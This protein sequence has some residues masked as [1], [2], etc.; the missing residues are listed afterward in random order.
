[1]SFDFFL[2]ALI[3]GMAFA[4]LGLGVYLTLRIFNIPDITT[5]GS[6]TLGGVVTALALVAGWH[7]LLAIVASGLAGSL[8][9]A[10]CGLIHT[11]LNTAPLLAGI[12]MMTALYSV[13]LIALGRPNLPLANMEPFVVLTGLSNPNQASLVAIVLLALL[14]GAKLLYLL[15]TDFGLAMRA[16]GNSEAMVRAIGV[17]VK[18]MKVIGLALANALTAISGSL[19]TQYQG[20]ADINMGIGIV[21]AGLAAVMIGEAF[22]GKNTGRSLPIQILAVIAGGIVFRMAIAGAL[23]AGLD[24]GYLRL[25][26]AVIVLSIIA[27]GNLRKPSNA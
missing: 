17:N 22:S 8:A 5:D 1:M 13:N 23:S 6:Y 11:R 9:G 27:L 18:S 10:G 19:I 12:L 21:I 24:P 20:F 2:T 4:G 26:T 3:Q 14:I 7:P 15:K 16:T 25:I